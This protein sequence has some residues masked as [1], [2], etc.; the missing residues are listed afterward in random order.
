MLGNLVKFKF[1]MTYTKV[2]MEKEPNG[3][4]RF[5]TQPGRTYLLPFHNPMNPSVP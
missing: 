3:V 4:F 5:N 1:M 2:K